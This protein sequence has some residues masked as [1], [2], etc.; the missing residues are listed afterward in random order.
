M[1]SRH[2]LSILL[3]LLLM[4]GVFSMCLSEAFYTS[5]AALQVYSVNGDQGEYTESDPETA[6]GSNPV[7]GIL[8]A[9]L[10]ALERCKSPAAGMAGPHQ[11]VSFL[12]SLGWML[13]LRI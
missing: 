2:P 5:E 1:T 4:A 7:V 10:S 12:R 13:P 11:R 3:L 8:G 9:A 6:E